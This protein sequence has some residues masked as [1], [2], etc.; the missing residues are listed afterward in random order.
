[1]AH[2]IDFYAGSH[3]NFLELL[4]H[5]YV[6]RLPF[7]L[8][9]PI[10]TNLGACHTKY[11][12]HLHGEYEQNIRL[13][14]YSASGVQIDP[15]DHVIQIHILDQ[16]K[17]TVAVNNYLRAG[18]Q[19]VDIY[20]LDQDSWHKLESMPKTKKWLPM[21]VARYG[22]RAEYPRPLLRQWFY[23]DFC[24]GDYHQFR[25]SG[26]RF[27]F[28]HEKFFD[29]NALCHELESCADWLG[30]QF[31]PDSTLG[32]IW[33]QFMHLNQGLESYHR[34]EQLLHDIKHGQRVGLQGLSIVEE[35]WLI[36]Q[37]YPADRAQKYIDDFPAESTGLELPRG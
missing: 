29:F 7:D 24:G 9:Q 25:H 32:P 33:E 31:Q 22:Q 6:L 15:Q 2:K 37:L 34:C 13:F 3:G 20:H 27:V 5:I 12:P 28:R 21:L 8:D 16:H 4:L 17:I 35:A 26:P 23:D 14:H 10:F 36:H 18:N 30:L 19:S 1:M 11:R